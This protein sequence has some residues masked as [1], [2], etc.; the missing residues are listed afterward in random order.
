M[1]AARRHAWRAARQSREYLP[2]GGATAVDAG[3]AFGAGRPGF[4]ALAAAIAADAAGSGGAALAGVTT[5]AEAEAEGAADGDA[6]ATAC[7][8]GGAAAGV[9]AVTG[10][11]ASPVAG[12]RCPRLASPKATSPPARTAAAATTTPIERRRCGDASG[13]E[14]GAPVACERS[15]VDSAGPDTATGPDPLTA[16]ASPSLG[17]EARASASPVTGFDGSSVVGDAIVPGCASGALVTPV[18]SASASSREAVAA[19]GKRAAGSFAVI[20]A[21]QRSNSGGSTT[22]R[23]AART[24]GGS[25]GPFIAWRA[26]PKTLSAAFSS[27]S[28]YALPTSSVYVMSPSA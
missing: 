11:F 20:R 14:S 28:Q 19:S 12:A 3:V 21:N 18:P 27:W 9:E 1:V 23:R 17:L 4:F 22:P 15:P 13:I 8:P 10:A 16:P 25:T 7:A 26:K 24:D 2:A 5:G 6:E